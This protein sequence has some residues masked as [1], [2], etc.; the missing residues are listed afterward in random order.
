MASP[1]R[2]GV[3]SADCACR[4]WGSPATAVMAVAGAF[5]QKKSRSGVSLPAKVTPSLAGYSLWG[6]MVNWTLA[7]SALLTA[8][9]AGFWSKGVGGGNRPIVRALSVLPAPGGASTDLNGLAG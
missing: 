8:C 3:R 1:A 4:Y 9:Q 7:L 6:T 5:A 2:Y